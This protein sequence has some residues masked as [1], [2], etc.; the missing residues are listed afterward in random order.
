[1]DTVLSKYDPSISLFPAFLVSPRSAYPSYTS[2][3]LARVALWDF[4]LPLAEPGSFIAKEVLK[5][6]SESGR[7]AARVFWSLSPGPVPPACLYDHAMIP[8]PDS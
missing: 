8:C 7:K 4:S 3:N 6:V 5:K 1:M 2:E